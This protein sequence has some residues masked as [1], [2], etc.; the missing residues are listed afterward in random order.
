MW[1]RAFVVQGRAR[2]NCDSRGHG[3]LCCP[4]LFRFVPSVS[5]PGP[6]FF[7]DIKAYVGF[8]EAD[9][10][11]LREFGTKVEG[12]LIRI[13]DVFYERMLGHP[14][15][16][17]VFEDLSQVQRLKYTL[18][19]WFRSGLSG[20][21][22]EAFYERRLQ[23]GRRHVQIEL[24]QQY[25]FTAM[26]VVRLELRALVEQHESADSQRRR[27]LSDAVDRWLD[28]ELAIMLKSY[29]DHSDALLARKE[30]LAGIGQ[31]AGTIGHELRNPL[32][33]IESSLYLVRRRLGEDDRVSK[34]LD[35]I[36]EQVRSAGDIITDLL[37]LVRDQAPKRELVELRPLV[38][39]C[40]HELQVPSGVSFEV[41]VPEGMTVDGD[42][43]LI[44]RAVVNLV[45]NAF[46]A[47]LEHPGVVSVSALAT[48]SEIVIE[49]VDEGPGFEP[50]ILRSAFEPLVTT[51]SQG[52]GLGLALVQRVAQR[53]GGS[54]EA[55]N[56]AT[57][58]ALV[59]L[60]LPRRA[61]AIQRS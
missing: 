8:G 31:V 15:A 39:R 1:R 50:E 61:P 55:E 6:S 58:G 29:R 45:K 14:G 10:T 46:E 12:D 19:E 37:D 34:H 4:G 42:A 51:R 38:E 22:G 23:I 17:R 7:E 43:K 49:V 35:R 47:M 57:G 56:R 52:V 36:E 59:R 26:D 11:L 24:P 3:D 25:M 40:L 16:M 54:A 53:H 28:L 60:S 48:A 18:V 27:A 20:P 30:R 13:S 5:V 9:S 33:V 2:R 41:R 32:G 44:C 21:H